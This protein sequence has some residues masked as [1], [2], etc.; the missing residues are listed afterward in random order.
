MIVT[1]PRKTRTIQLDGATFTLGQLTASDRVVLAALMRP[2]PPEG[3]PAEAADLTP[4][5]TRRASLDA[6]IETVRRALRGWSGVLYPD[7]AAVPFVYESGRAC[8]S[9]ETVGVLSLLAISQLFDEVVKDLTIT[10]SDHSKSP[11]SGG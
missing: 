7:G 9:L 1:D 2:R 10:P 3:A 6:M 5:E 8:A 11:S 4:I